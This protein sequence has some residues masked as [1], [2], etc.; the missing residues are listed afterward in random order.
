MAT[1]QEW[2]TWDEDHELGLQS[3]AVFEVVEGV[4]RIVA[5]HETRIRES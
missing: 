5:I 2:Q 4:P 3:T 1:Y